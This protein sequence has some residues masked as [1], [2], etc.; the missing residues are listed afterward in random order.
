MQGEKRGGKSN[1]LAESAREQQDKT[2]IWLLWGLK[3]FGKMFYRV[4]QPSAVAD[5]WSL[6]HVTINTNY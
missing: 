1:R 6:T 4:L 5:G 2:N 3:V